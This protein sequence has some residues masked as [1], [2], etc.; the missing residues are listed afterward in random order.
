MSSTSSGNRQ[1][2]RRELSVPV[3]VGL[4]VSLFGASLL[5]Q[6]DLPR[7]VDATATRSFLT[8]SLSTW[9]LVA[10]VLAI[11]LYWED[12]RLTS[13][14]LRA[15]TRRETAVGLGAGLLGVVLGLLSTGIA[16][17]ALQ[18]QQPET[19]SAL[20][21]LSLP[22]QLVIVVT[23]VVTEEILWRGYPIERLAEV[24]GSVWV[25][26]GVSGV[27]FLAVHF[28]AWGLVG[29]IPQAVFT[30]VIVGV[31]VW[32][33]NVVACMLTHGVINVVMILVLPVFL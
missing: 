8:N 13:I 32:S 6:L 26:A 23:A 29:A 28:P 4:F 21:R 7:W 3:I 22:V 31:Y 27:V 24:T 12:R 16:V 11:V 33:R 15:P 18:L 20:S 5:G 17:V 1:L 9:L 25:G 10:L 30:L 14:G 19:L 2:S